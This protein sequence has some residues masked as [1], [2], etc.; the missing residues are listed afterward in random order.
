MAIGQDKTLRVK[1]LSTGGTIEKVY[2]EYEGILHNVPSRF[3]LILTRMRLPSVE[4]DQD[5][6]MSKD[7]LVMTD[8][9]RVI[10]RE[11]V[12]A[13]PSNFD[14]VLV[15][16]GT[17]TLEQTGDVLYEGLNDINRPIIL[18]GAMRPFEFRDTDAYQNIYESLI[19]CRLL[20]PGVYCVMHSKVLQFPGV[21]KNRDSLTFE[22]RAP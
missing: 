20:T 16:H 6:L 18:T 3:E 4:V 19:A 9:D 1:V 22:K 2:D 21:T 15:V 14:A 17:D 8:D 5:R 7:S 10:I 13:V 11:A 12:Q